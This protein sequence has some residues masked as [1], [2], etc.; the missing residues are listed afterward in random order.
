MILVNARGAGECIFPDV[1][2]YIC[3]PDT[4]ENIRT[5]IMQGVLEV[6]FS[7]RQDYI[8]V[9]RYRLKHRGCYHFSLSLLTLEAK[10]RIGHTSF[11]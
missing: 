4:A 10:Y 5:L 1:G 3:F 11:I 8:F 2:L 7:R 6:I 9:T